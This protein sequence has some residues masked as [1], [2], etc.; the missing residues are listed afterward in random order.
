MGEE[1]TKVLRRVYGRDVALRCEC[2]IYSDKVRL[3]VSSENVSLL[4]R[5]ARLGQESLATLELSN[6]TS[7]TTLVLSTPHATIIPRLVA[8]VGSRHIRNVFCFLKPRHMHHPR[9]QWDLLDNMME[10][11]F[12]QGATLHIGLVCD[13]KANYEMCRKDFVWNLPK[14]SSRAALHVEHYSQ[15]QKQVELEYGNNTLHFL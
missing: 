15:V 12:F 10:S 4:L 8:T 7:L 14:C 6:Y 11:T 1:G 5:L 3:L 9:Y 2:S 13:S